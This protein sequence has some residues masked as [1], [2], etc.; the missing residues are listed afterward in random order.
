MKAL[1]MADCWESMKAACSVDQLAVA[2]DALRVAKSALS[3]AALKVDQL[4]VCS[5]G[6]TVDY[7]ADK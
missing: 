2:T 7:S 6:T 3:M 4:A 5:A 1:Q